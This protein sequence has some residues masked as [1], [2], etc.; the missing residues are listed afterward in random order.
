MYFY[1]Q[2]HIP[3]LRYDGCEKW[4]EFFHYLE[5]LLTPRDLKSVFCKHKTKSYYAVAVYSDSRHQMCQQTF[6]YR[7]VINT[8]Y[9]NN[10]IL[11]NIINVSKRRARDRNV[12]SNFRLLERQFYALSS[13]DTVNF[14]LSSGICFVEP[15]KLL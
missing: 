9:N 4:S 11:Y 10:I 14:R 6:V 1:F 5:R 15:N 13:T 8:L 12:M 2:L 3:I 7:T